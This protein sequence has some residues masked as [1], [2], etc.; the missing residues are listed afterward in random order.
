MGRTMPNHVEGFILSLFLNPCQR[1]LTYDITKT[2]RPRKREALNLDLSE[3]TGMRKVY[4]D[5]CGV[6][7]YVMHMEW[8]HMDA[9]ADRCGKDSRNPASEP[10]W[11]LPRVHA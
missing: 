9:N 4:M 5:A 2:S 11:G 6:D 8:M 10:S 1:C 7:A 3:L